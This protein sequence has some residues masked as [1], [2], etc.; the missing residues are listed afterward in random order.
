[1]T[2]CITYE[3]INHWHLYLIQVSTGD[4]L[5]AQTFNLSLNSKI[6]L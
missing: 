2:F 3:A 5:Q 1:M 6:K 4:V